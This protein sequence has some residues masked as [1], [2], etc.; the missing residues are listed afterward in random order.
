MKETSQRRGRARNHSSQRDGY[1][2]DYIG[3]QKAQ[4]MQQ[5]IDADEQ[6]DYNDLNEEFG[7]VSVSGKYKLRSYIDLVEICAQKFTFIF[8]CV[9]D[10][11]DQIN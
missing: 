11:E 6:I 2:T 1:H 7:N 4:K 9:L 8:Y 3:R 5:Q 10:E